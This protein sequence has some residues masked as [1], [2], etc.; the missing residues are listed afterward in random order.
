MPIT[1]QEVTTDS[2]KVS[3][4]RDVLADLPK[5]FGIP[6]TVDEYAEEVKKHVFIKANVDNAPIGFVSVK[7]NNSYTSEI[8]LVGIKS[9]YHRN[10]IGEKLLSYVFDRLRKEKCSIVMV[11][12]LDESKLS[13]EYEK[14]RLFYY[15]MGFIPLDVIPSIWG[16]ENPCLIM[17]KKL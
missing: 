4:T 12:T 2:E 17:V 6:S 13:E 8:Y 10:K 15:K 9:K 14:T 16:K 11:K 3:I 5:W 7:S 1:F